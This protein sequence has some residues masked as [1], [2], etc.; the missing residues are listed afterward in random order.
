MTEK[1]LTAEQTRAVKSFLEGYRLN[2]KLLRLNKYEKDYL[3]GDKI[4]VPPEDT[5]LED[6]LARARM[7]EVRHFILGLDNSDEKLFLYYKYVKG[8]SV[9]NCAE[10]LG[11]SRRTAYRLFS[12]ALYMAYK[13]GYGTY[14]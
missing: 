13:Y 1:S 12:K 4:Y 11:I 10:L 2:A 6:P 14:F 5:P 3:G 7:F 8:E 9:E